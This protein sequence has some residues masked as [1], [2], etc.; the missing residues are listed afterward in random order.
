MR[1]LARKSMPVLPAAPA[2]SLAQALASV[3]DRRQPFGWRQGRAPLPLVAVL[4]VSVTALVCGAQSLAAIAQWSRERLEDAPERLLALGRPPGRTP[5][6]AT[7]GIGSS[8][9]EMWPP[10]SARWGHG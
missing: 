9:R 5:S 6:V 4:Q 2:G 8:R 7:P 3:P 10:S 1:H